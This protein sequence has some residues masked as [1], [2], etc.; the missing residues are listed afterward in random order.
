M[1]EYSS[2]IS[3]DNELIFRYKS[4]SQQSKKKETSRKNKL[5]FS[6]LLAAGKHTPNCS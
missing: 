2:Q 5:G 3:D 6:P 1:A 4:R